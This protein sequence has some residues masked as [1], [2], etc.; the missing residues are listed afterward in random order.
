MTAP[1]RDY[2]VAYGAAKRWFE[3]ESLRLPDELIESLACA[4][5][6]AVDEARAKRQQEH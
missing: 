1:D 2:L 5:L 4:V 6:D 3:R